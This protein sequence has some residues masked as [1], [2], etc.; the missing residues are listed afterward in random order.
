MIDKIISNLLLISFCS[1]IFAQNN[2]PFTI[3]KF[4][5]DI[6]SYTS[7]I[8]NVISAPVRLNPNDLLVFGG[9]LASVSGSFLLDHEIN[10][11]FT[12]NRFKSLDNL[13]SLGDYYGSPMSTVSVSLGVYFISDKIIS[14]KKGENSFLNNFTFSPN[15]NGILFIYN[16]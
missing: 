4:S 14:L 3:T 8:E 7:S 9:F 5:D 13:E 1:I 16:F 2:Q 6:N 12:E 11:F 10:D 15:L